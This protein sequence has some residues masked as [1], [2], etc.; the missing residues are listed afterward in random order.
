MWDGQKHK[1]NKKRK[2]IMEKKINVIVNMLLSTWM[3]KKKNAH[4]WSSTDILCIRHKKMKKMKC[5]WNIMYVISYLLILELKFGCCTV[6]KDQNGK[7]LAKS[8]T[9]A[10]WENDEWIDMYKKLKTFINSDAFLLRFRRLKH[11]A[12]TSIDLPCIFTFPAQWA[13]P[14]FFFK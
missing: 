5:F 12:C 7:N 4:I 9:K 13:T 1:I 2:N 14:L 6:I 8:L 3:L 10:S 11:P